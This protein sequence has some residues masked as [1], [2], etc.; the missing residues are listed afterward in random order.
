MRGS[1]LVTPDF[2]EKATNV[3]TE[4]Y[5]T[6]EILIDQQYDLKNQLSHLVEEVTEKLL[7]VEEMLRASENAAS[8]IG[9]EQSDRSR[10][11][12]QSQTTAAPVGGVSVQVEGFGRRPEQSDQQSKDLTHLVERLE[13]FEERLGVTLESLFA[14]MDRYGMIRIAGELHPRTGPTLNQNIAIRASCHDASGRVVGTN[15]YGIFYKD[16][17][18]GLQVFEFVINSPSLANVKVAKIRIFPEKE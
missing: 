9:A 13:M 4:I 1:S 12:T 2:V 11:L 18:F 15:R 5:K 6:N 3:L 10:D 8:P 17:L 7:T 14:S 16:K